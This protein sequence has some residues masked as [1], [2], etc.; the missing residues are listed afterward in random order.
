MFARIF[1]VV[2]DVGFRRSWYRRK[3]CASLSLKVL[4]LRETE[5]GLER[6]GS[7][8]RGH[9]SVFGL[10]EGIFPIKIPARPGKIQPTMKNYLKV[11]TWFMVI[12]KI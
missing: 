12:L 9:Q 6:Y 7:V 5:L 3:D 1:D 8:N 2:S 10:L 11:G 4:D